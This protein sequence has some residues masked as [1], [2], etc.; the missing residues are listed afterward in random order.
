MGGKK[1][2]LK[3]ELDSPN[4]YMGLTPEEVSKIT[5]SKEHK[6][7]IQ[8]DRT[9]AI[10]RDTLER[11]DLPASERIVEILPC[12]TLR[13]THVFILFLRDFRMGFIYELALF[14]FVEKKFEWK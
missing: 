13:K 1:W 12:R 4:K 2:G 14:D 10:N 8:K 6:W 11:I 9:S 3:Y 7:R 5:F